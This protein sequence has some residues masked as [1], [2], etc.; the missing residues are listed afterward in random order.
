MPSTAEVNEMYK[1]IFQVNNEKKSVVFNK[2]L[3]RLAAVFEWA[4]EFVAKHSWTD[5]YKIMPIKQRR[6]K[7]EQSG[8]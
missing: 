6:N 3:E 8:N 7:N 2:D 4:D 5:E 1:V